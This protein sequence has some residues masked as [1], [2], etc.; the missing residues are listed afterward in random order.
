MTHPSSAAPNLVQTKPGAEAIPNGPP[1][2]GPVKAGA[3][4]HPMLY[5]INTRCWL[6]DLSDK[7]GCQ[8]TLGNV[9]ES[10]FVT[11]QDLGF[12]HL[13]LMGVWT[14]GPKSRAEAL[15]HP[16]LHRKYSEALP[17]WKPADVG[18]SP[19]AIAEYRV[20]AALG[21]EEGLQRFRTKLHEFG[22]KLV[23]DFVPNHVGLD[24]RWVEERPELFVESE[25]PAG[26]TFRRE[27]HNGVRWLA[28]GKDPFF[29][30]WT[31]TVQLDYRRAATREAIIEVL[32]S[33][34]E[35]CD[36][37]RC[38]MAMLVL[39]DVFAKTWEHIPLPDHL[40][41]GTKRTDSL[42]PHEGRYA[43]GEFWAEA[44]YWVKS[45]YP[46][47]LFL[48]ESYWGLEPRLHALGFDFTYDKGL[49]DQIVARNTWAVHEH[50]LG[51][52][53]QFTEASAHFLEN[54]D[55][56][57]IASLLSLPEHRAAALLMLGL[58]GMRF[59]HEGQLFGWKRQ[60][61]VQLIRRCSEPVDLQ[62]ENFYVK[63]LAAFGHSAVGRGRGELLRAR[64]AS[65][66]NP[67]AQNFSIAQWQSH[68]MQ[69]DLVVV[70]L[71]PHR[72]QCFVPL[73]VP[74]LAG[75]Q[76]TMKDLLG[77]EEYIRDGEEMERQGLYL[78]VE[79]HAA[80]LFHFQTT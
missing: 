37:I 79:A 78:D 63:M 54:H 11:W 22:I 17:D 29:A 32:L 42:G 25:Q 61:P 56:A 65:P 50:L 52:L 5:E 35:R 75:H 66:D 68:R 10:L 40:G 27:G 14:S 57:R 60:I 43:S 39:S 62:I 3:K 13:W 67:T 28:H 44:I 71:A 15:G 18:A 6:R 51:R 36:G 8:I 45:S 69:F 77:A 76:W 16:D 46:E 53:L 7:H 21:G 49:Y 30:P 59:L 73:T 72:S 38:D 4:V 55:E 19:Y 31:D 80:Q 64:A 48:A 2:P 47:F 20:P 74:N 1:T 70:N 24:H 41:S 33:V 23:L 34:A 12:T 58:P 9:P 26:G